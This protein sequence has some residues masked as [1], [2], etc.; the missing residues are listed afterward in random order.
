MKATMMLPISPTLPWM[1]RPTRKPPIS[2]PI[3]PMIRSPM[4]P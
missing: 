1:N 2:A 3:R 4:M